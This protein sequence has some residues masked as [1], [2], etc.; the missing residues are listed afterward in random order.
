MEAPLLAIAIIGFFVGLT[1]GMFGIG[2]SVI[3]I[4]A[5]T[6]FRG[7]NQHLYQAT[8]MIMNFCVSAPALW[9][10]WRAGA[11][12]PATIA[13]LMPLSIVFVAVGVAVSE[14]PV[15]AGSGEAYLRGLFGL[16]LLG[17]GVA[18]L[19][20]N[21]SRRLEPIR[22]T[23]ANVWDDRGSLKWSAITGIAAPTGLI[24][25]L[26][27]VGGG[28]LAV[29]LQRRFLHIAMPIAIANS[30]ALVAATAVFGAVMKN[31]AYWSTHGSA[32]EPIALAL[33]LAPTAIIGSLIGARLTHRAP[34][35]VL[36]NIFVALLILAA[37]RLIHGAL[38]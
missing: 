15:F 13:R 7:P 14:L 11:I 22:D 36:R 27:G 16:F 6:E 38:S 4:P 10:H 5:L 8:A 32:R 2:G 9:Q 12:R 20:R 19:L 18:E 33:V 23:E 29:P 24:S 37:V 34:L 30:T 31:Y 26:L 3:L 28:I 17:C 25:G 21:R 35:K 1:G